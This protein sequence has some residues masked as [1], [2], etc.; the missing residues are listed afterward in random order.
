MAFGQH[1]TVPPTMIDIQLVRR[2]P[3]RVRAALARR[4]DTSDLDRLVVS[5]TR[6][7]EQ[8]GRRD[9][10][11]ARV[12]SLSRDVAEAR[13]AQDAARAEELA[14]QSRS[15][16]QE[17]KALDAEV[18]ALE[19]ER[20]E[21]LLGI[22]NLPDAEVP[23]GSSPAD[24]VIRR[25]WSPGP[26]T[27]GRPEPPDPSEYGAHQRVPHWEIGAELGLLDLERGSRLSGSMFPVYRG[28]GAKVLRAMNS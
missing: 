26:G 5:D 12:K 2:D 20:R 21:L 25:W 8:T 1:A 14:G 27:E 3:D 6:W 10:V 19:A 15:L 4:G 7:R 18:A 23:D 22:P 16:G 17:E 24:N 13:R 28:M 9:E 11:R